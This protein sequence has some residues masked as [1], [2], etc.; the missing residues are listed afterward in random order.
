MLNEV[1]ALEH[2]L[3]AAGFE[4]DARHADVQSPGRTDALRV[5]LDGTG[6]PVEA[7]ALD[8][9][10]LASL[11]TLRNGKH[12]SFPYVQL[13]RPL[14]SI[15]D[16]EDW[17]EEH[18]DA[19]KGMAQGDRRQWL[20]DLARDFPPFADAGA[21]LVAKG[22][23]D[24]LEKR[25]EALAALEGLHASVP[26]VI[27]RFLAIGD[28]A[29]F[30]E[31]FVALLLDELD[32]ADEPLLQAAHVALVGRKMQGNVAGIPL[33]FDVRRNEFDRD[34]ADPRHVAA[35]SLALSG[36]ALA[37]SARGICLLTGEEAALHSGNFPQPSVPVL[38]QIYLFSKNGDIPAA[39]RYGRADTAGLPVNTVLPPRFA[40][41]LCAITQAN[42]KGRTWRSIPSEKPK[43]SDLLIAFVDGVP[44]APVTEAIA[45]EPSDEDDDNLDKEETGHRPPEE[46]FEIAAGA[47][48]GAYLARADRLMEAVK[49]KVGEDFRRPLVSV[50]VL[51]KVDTGNAKAILHR[52]LTVGAIYDSAK[53]WGEALRNLPPW[54]TMPRPTKDR[55]MRK[56]GAPAIAPLQL[57]RATRA[58]FIRG[59]TERAG[60]EPVG[61]MAADALA[62]F[63]NEAGAER[64]AR[65]A[66]RTVLARQRGLLTGAAHALRKDAGLDG[67]KHAR[68]F[69]RAAAL[70]TAGLLG[71]LLAKLNRKGEAY[72]KDGAFRL[73][74]LLAM[75]DA[76]HVGYCMDVRGGVVPPTLLGNSVLATAQTDP[77]RALAVLCR[78]WKPY[79]GWRTR[80]DGEEAQRLTQSEDAKGRAK[81][82]AIRTALSQAKRFKPFAAELAHVLPTASDID[83]A[84]RAELLLGYV[85]GLPKA[86]RKSDDAEGGDRP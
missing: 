18:D 55:R 28:G 24:S 71:L 54:L 2:A 75:A 50:L 51:R 32:E 15:P 62:L 4:F 13:K 6:A 3:S 70:Q 29:A 77:Q 56:R 34:V 85:A 30:V 43:A 21:A 53:A 61:I 1:F 39:A 38:G 83:D 12:N 35:I 86:E 45:G 84:F 10:R 48:L 31:A 49:A 46:A 74:Q 73:G 59:G 76:V 36:G 78:R 14:L 52:A 47:A 42:L 40:G 7:S 23:R 26:A 57:P 27:A 72:M 41:A 69:D 11:W 58:M 44:D 66:L 60:R 65:A 80:A 17:R 20:R 22:F 33:L 81:G 16:S 9:D 63:L 82:W 19:W 25:R 8:R 79:W 5:R 68:D 64:I 67:F 37:S